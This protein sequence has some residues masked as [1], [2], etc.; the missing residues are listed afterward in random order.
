MVMRFMK[1][2]TINALITLIF[3]LSGNM[4]FGRT[5]F[6]IDRDYTKYCDV[7]DEY[8]YNSVDSCNCAPK[9]YVGIL[10]ISAPQD[11]NLLVNFSKLYNNNRG[12]S[13]M[14]EDLVEI[15]DPRKDSSYQLEF[16]LT[17]I[18]RNTSKVIVLQSHKKIDFQELLPKLR[19]FLNE[20]D[21]IESS[22]PFVK[23]WNIP[24]DIIL[25]PCIP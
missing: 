3:L 6:K 8:E 2:S 16:L 18:R 20:S 5:D 14:F 9:Y 17:T 24:S 22:N 15:N 11:K 10:K 13:L 12:I 21:N 7:V 4:L 23:E 1:T 25:L 19:I